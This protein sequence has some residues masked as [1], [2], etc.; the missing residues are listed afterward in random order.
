MVRGLSVRRSENEHP[1]QYHKF[2]ED[3]DFGLV[4]YTP[5]YL[6]EDNEKFIDPETNK[7]VFKGY[8]KMLLRVLLLVKTPLRLTIPELPVPQDLNTYEHLVV[9]ENE[10]IA[11]PY[12]E[13]SYKLETLVEW[14]GKYRFGPWFIVDIDNFMKGNSPMRLHQPEEEL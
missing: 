11:P 13:S 4:T 9:M 10:M 6:T 2:A 7:T 5:K 12:L 1:S 14:L 3:K 8:E